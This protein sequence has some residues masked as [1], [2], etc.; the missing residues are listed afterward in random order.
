M[1]D[2]SILPA[3]NAGGQPLE[4]ILIAYVGTEPVASAARM[5]DGRWVVVS[6]VA[7]GQIVTDDLH[8][9]FTEVAR[10]VAAL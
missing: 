4:D 10:R 8:A 3:R 5:L 7:D 9:T 1:L 2:V 6:L